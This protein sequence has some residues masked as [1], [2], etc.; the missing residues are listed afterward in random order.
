MTGVLATPAW[1]QFWIPQTITMLEV[2]SYTVTFL[3]AGSASHT[4]GCI[5]VFGDPLFREADDDITEE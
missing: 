3:V 2:P 1:Y 4:T 5:L